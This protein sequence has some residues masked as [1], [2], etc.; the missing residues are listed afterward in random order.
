MATFAQ[1][2]SFWHLNYEYMGKIL[3]VVLNSTEELITP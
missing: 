2:Q 3:E 1:G